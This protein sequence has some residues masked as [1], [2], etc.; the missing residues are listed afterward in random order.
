MF[1][2][3]KYVQSLEKEVEELQT[4][5]IKLSK[6]YDLLLEE[7]FLKDIMC[8]ILCSF[9]SLDEKTELQYL[10]AQVQD[11]NIAISELKKLIENMKGKSVD[12]KF[13]KPSVVRQLNAFKLQKP[14]VLGK[15]SPFLNSSFIKFRNQA[16]S[17]INVIKSGMYQ[18]DTGTTQTR[19][20]QLNQTFRNTN[21]RVSTST[22]VIHRTSVSRPQLRSNQMKDKVVQNNSQVKIKQKEAKDHHRISSFSNKAKSVT[23]CNDSLKSRTSNVNV[24]CVTCGNC[25]FN[26]NHDACVSKFINDVNARSKKPNVEPI[27][28]SKPTRKVN[29][30]VATPH[31][32]IV[33]SEPTIQKSRS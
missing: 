12:T 7:W 4:D 21:P 3:L 16:V 24:V 11:K 10:K 32:K 13:E 20:A 29:Q 27:S 30:Y 17:N 19:A 33:A 18:I 5:K 23:A 14:S 15:L 9:K 22:G 6:E 25:V 2:D 28:A 26:S 1:S 8:S 31:K